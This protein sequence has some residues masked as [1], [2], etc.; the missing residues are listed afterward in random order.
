MASGTTAHLLAIHGSSE[1][2]IVAVGANG[3]V[4]R[5]AGNEWTAMHP[6]IDDSLTLVWCDGPDDIWAASPAGAVIHFDGAGWMRTN[7]QLNLRAYDTRGITHNAIWGAGEDLYIATDAG[8]LLQYRQAP[9]T[10]D[11]LSLR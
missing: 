3:T 7:T 10:L 1:Q 11:D 2:N 9:T 6:A 5:N 4:L 8:F